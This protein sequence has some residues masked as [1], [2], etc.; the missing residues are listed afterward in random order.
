MNDTLPP[1]RTEKVALAPDLRALS[2][3]AVRAWTERMAVR[4]LGDAY[5]VD[6]ESGATYV[7]DPVEGTCTC[8]DR[9]L[10]G[11][12]C[13]HLR[14]VA[15]EITAERVPPPGHRR[16]QCVACGTETFAPTDAEEPP[17]CSACALEP[18]EV[19]VDRKT[20]G[21][22][23]VVRVRPDRAD[24]VMIPETNTTVADYS[25]NQGYPPG[26]IVVEAVYAGAVSRE[27]PRR[28]SFPLSRLQRTDDAA[29]VD[30]PAPTPAEN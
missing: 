13:K 22:L 2:Q 10:R 16:E 29:I 9:Q 5:A 4:P 28:Y 25:T 7:V 8:P 11:E 18:G 15:I 12:T 21:R 17:L 6:S 19:V 27:T 14:R 26:D 23:V 24:E 3:R 30:P 20:G 1:E